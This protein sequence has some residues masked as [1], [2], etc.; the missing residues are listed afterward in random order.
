[1]PVYLFYGEEDF[2]IDEKI[3]ELKSKAASV[4]V[5]DGADISLESLSNALCGY[6][7]FGGEKMVIVRGLEIE[8]EIQDQ[9]LSLLKNVP[10]GT[11]VVF[12]LPEVDKRSKFFKW[13]DEHGETEEF[14]TFAP[15]DQR[16]P[17]G[18][19]SA[20]AAAGGKKISGGATR[21]LQEICGNNLR[22]LT[23]EIEKLI[24]YIGDRKEIGED[25]VAA[26]ASPGEI[27]AFALLDALRGKNLKQSLTAFQ[28]L[29]K[30]GEDYFH[31]LSMIASQYRLMLQI[32]DPGSPNNRIKGSPYFIRKCS[33]GLD[34]FTVEELKSAM[35]ALLETNLKLKTGQQQSVVFE[36]L[37]ASL[38]GS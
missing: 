28:S 20:R 37:I 14:K 8:D 17:Q 9:L 24:T 10:S 3:K 36:L 15:W 26:L 11:T 1:M 31:L 30:N 7:L 23:G 6:S 38:C 19:I 21:L 34:R 4:E 18:W 35:G 29:I 16:G 33:E 25:D 27:N 32:K 22:L 5:L 12:H 2:L 13:V